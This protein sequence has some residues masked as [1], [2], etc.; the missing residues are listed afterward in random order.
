MSIIIFKRVNY[1]MNHNF[2]LNEHEIQNVRNQYCC[3]LE[4]RYKILW[5]LIG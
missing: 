4:I 2:A 3:S 5:F 1:E